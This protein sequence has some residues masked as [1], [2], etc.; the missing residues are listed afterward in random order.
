MTGDPERTSVAPAEQVIVDTAV[1]GNVIIERTDD[2]VSARLES[3][4][5]PVVTI[6]RTGPRTR[7]RVP[8]GTRR[9]KHL[10]A[11]VNERPLALT[12]GRGWVMKRSYRIVVETEGRYLSLRARNL[13]TSVFQ[14]GKLYATDK[15]MAELTARADGTVD[16]LWATP[17]KVSALGKTLAFDPPEPT[18]EDLLIGYAAAAAFGTGGLSLFGLVSL[19]IDAIPL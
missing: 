13:E 1:Y 16:V 11:R 8:I 9:T 12:L 19:L 3:D 10:T 5:S 2:R 15:E 18:A 4:G 6:E 14:Q 17:G 7:K